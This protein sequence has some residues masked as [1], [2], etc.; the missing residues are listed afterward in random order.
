M[1]E[2]FDE[3]FSIAWPTIVIVLSIAIILRIF[4]LK[5][6]KKKFVLHEEIFLLI[7]LTY[8]LVLF[9]LVTYQDI[10]ISGTN[11]M[12]FKEIL[13]YDFGS[14]SFYKQVLGNILLFVPFGYFATRYAKVNKLG[15]IFFIGI[16]TSSI[17]ETVQY[18]I[19]RCFD[20]DDIILNVV[21]TVL[22]F[23]IFTACDAIK[24]KLPS[25]FQKDFIYNIISIVL[26]ILVV[27]YVLKIYNVGF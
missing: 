12:P 9:E 3:V 11:F 17:I 1:R 21:G 7:F 25:L 22:G 13:R 20:I 19:G 2:I 8:I 23:L 4:Y 16:F 27:L 5:Q 18:F 15:S 26:I 14:T 10:E 6:N 24:K